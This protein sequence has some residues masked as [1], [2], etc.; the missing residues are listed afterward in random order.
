LIK[1]E[2]VVAHLGERA[3]PRVCAIFHGTTSASCS[4]VTPYRSL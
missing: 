3:Q 2:L 1:C 4:S